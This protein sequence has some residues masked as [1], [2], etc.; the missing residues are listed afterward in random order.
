MLYGRSEPTPVEHHM[1]SAIN[2]YGKR[3]REVFMRTKKRNKCKNVVKPTRK[4]IGFENRNI[5]II[6]KKATAYSRLELFNGD[7]GDGGE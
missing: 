3:L 4:Y 6:V 1:E 5:A 2:P 7:G